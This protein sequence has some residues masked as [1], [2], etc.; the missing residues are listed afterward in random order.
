M[1][2]ERTKP[3]EALPLTAA[4]RAPLIAHIIYRLDIGGME[5]GL[6]NL[7]NAIPPER[8]RHAV[9]CLT[10]YTDFRSRIRRPE[11]EYYA[12]HKR[13]GKDL[14]VSVRL[15]RLLRRLRPD[16]VHTRN[17][18]ALD[19]LVPATLAG[20]AARVHGEHGRDMIDLDGRNRKY[21][22]LRRLLRPLVHRYVPLSRDLEIWLRE[23]IGVPTE[24]IVRI[25]NGVDTE[26]FHPAAD[27]RVPL[28]VEGFAPPG[29]IV[30][31]TVGR[32]QAVKDQIT[33]VK[34]FL[35]LLE[36]APDF[37]NRLRLVLIGDGPLRAEAA[38]RLTSA[39][40]AELAWMPGA[41]DD[42]PELLRAFDIFVLPSIAEGISNTILE[43]M[44]SGL[45]VVA[46]RVGGNPELVVENVTG[47]LV[48]AA[49]PVA[50]AT[51]LS[52]YVRDP[53][54]GQ[55]HGDAGRKRV[56]SDFSLRVMVERYL[57]VYDALMTMRRSIPG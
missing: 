55:R 4:G 34:T 33:L 2:H 42:I 45:P 50:M 12:L 36:M 28:P 27:G 35:R 52:A 51:A 7:I 44:A 8:Y 19:S 57:A 37:R 53:A 21:N 54:Q 9:V 5:N 48:P 32:L 49:D 38:E 11:V 25:Y 17:L 31:G 15:W 6:V 56:Q 20:V 14:G 47:L 23:C 1:N 10:E 24:S 26:K 29:T 13:S 43:A 3:A 41:R 46:T 18:S 22:M 40:V 16:I 39:G 30:I